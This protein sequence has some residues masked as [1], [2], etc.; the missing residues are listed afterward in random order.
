MQSDVEAFFS[1]LLFGGFIWAGGFLLPTARRNHNVFGMVC[2]IGA[3][4]VALTAWLFLGT[5]LQSR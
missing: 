4:L 3:A 1:F 5:G 2:A